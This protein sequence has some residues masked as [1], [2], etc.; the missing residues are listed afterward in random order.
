LIL[1]AHVKED[2]AKRSRD[3]IVMTGVAILAPNVS[4]HGYLQAR[5]TYCEPRDK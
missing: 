3:P 5:G 2:D 4:R 1:S